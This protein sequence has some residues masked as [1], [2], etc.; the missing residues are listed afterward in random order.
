[1]TDSDRMLLKDSII[2]VLIIALVAGIT[3]YSISKL[4]PSTACINGLVHEKH[5]DYWIQ[6]KTQCIP[7]SK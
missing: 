6:T 3:I 1:M 7:V 5:D 2:S 4:T